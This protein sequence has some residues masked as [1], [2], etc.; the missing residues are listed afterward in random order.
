MTNKTIVLTY[1]PGADVYLVKF[2]KGDLGILRSAAIKENLDSY[3]FGPNVEQPN[4]QYPVPEDMPIVTL[5]EKPEP[6]QIPKKKE[7]LFSDVSLDEM[8]RRIEK[9]GVLRHSW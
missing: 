9:S 2:P 4:Y 8:R 7:D 5:D 3:D 6:T 1:Y